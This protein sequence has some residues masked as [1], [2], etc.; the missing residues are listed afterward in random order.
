MTIGS[1]HKKRNKNNTPKTVTDFIEGANTNIHAKEAVRKQ[2]PDDILLSFAGKIDR[3]NECVH[4]PV[5]L[6]LKKDVAADIEKYCY[7]NKQGILNYLIKMGLNEL[8]R[9]NKLQLIIE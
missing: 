4:K 6:Y 7:G 2:S 8:I 9:G 1:H 5:L 3:E